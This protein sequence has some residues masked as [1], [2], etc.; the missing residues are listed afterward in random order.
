MSFQSRRILL[1][2]FSSSSSSFL[3]KHFLSCE[4]LASKSIVSD[5]SSLKEGILESIPNAENSQLAASIHGALCLEGCFHT[6]PK[7]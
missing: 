3:I 4:K 5:H 6:G 2:R 1:S 7:L